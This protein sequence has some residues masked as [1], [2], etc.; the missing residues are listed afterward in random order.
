SGASILYNGGNPGVR[1]SRIERYVEFARL[2]HSQ[3]SRKRLH[4]VL[5]QQPYGFWSVAL[6]GEDHPCHAVSRL[7][8]LVVGESPVR[9]LYRHAVT[10]LLH[11]LFE[12]LR[13]RLL[14]LCLLK[15]HKGARWV[16]ALRPNGLLLQRKIC[17]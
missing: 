6:C 7:I 1:E 4:P 10:E 17:S 16:H 15:C 5:E 12:T 2:Q 9:R 11:L 8:Q 14:E 13:E 3:E